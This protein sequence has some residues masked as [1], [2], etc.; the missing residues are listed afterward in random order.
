MK[1]DLSIVPLF[2]VLLL[3]LIGFASYKV[4]AMD[5]GPVSQ[6]IVE[7]PAKDA[8][9]AAAQVDEEA[10]AEELP[11]ATIVALAVIVL[12]LALGN[13]RL[14]ESLKKIGW[15]QPNQAPTWQS[16]FGALAI[17]ALALAKYL[18][19]EGQITEPVNNL[20]EV[21]TA[22]S[23]LILA[24][25][26]AGLAKLIHEAWKRIGWVVAD[27]R[28]PDVAVTAVLAVDRG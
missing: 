11:P 15:I 18:G 14:V 6:M 20:V 26:Q 9:A 27:K 25:G 10:P 23:L 28:K 16:T 5:D 19:L 1:R 8:P 2:V 17:A 13:E 21:A 3:L 7:L 24:F 12:V 4:L 22:F